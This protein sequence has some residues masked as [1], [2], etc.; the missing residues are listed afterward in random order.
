MNGQ[1]K[2]NALAS[3]NELLE[4]TQKI[5]ELDRSS[6]DFERWHLDVRAAIRH[7]FGE[8]HK[9]LTEFE[10]I[11]FFSLSGLHNDAAA[12]Q[13][14]MQTAE[15]RLKSMADE[16][17]K[18]WP[19]EPTAAHRKTESGGRTAGTAATPKIF[20][21]HGH[22]EAA[23]SEVARFLVRLDLEPVILD[24]QASEGKTI[25]EKV[26]THADVGYAVA[27]LTA[28]DVGSR[29]GDVAVQPRARQNVIFEL[30]FFIGHLG[31]G[32]V[33]ALTKGEPEIPSDYSGVVYVSMESGEWKMALIKE[34]KAAGL[35]VDANKAFS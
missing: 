25:I 21:I 9:H 6:H 34:L 10:A 3:L 33:C 22:D 11:Y 8:E 14:S 17:D 20:L 28:D 15:T 4:R 24:E 31:R 12:F 27:L 26:E 30:G 23:K 1:S 18:F 29:Q 19:G 35:D 5:K 32:S 2:A 7:I 16:V 13:K